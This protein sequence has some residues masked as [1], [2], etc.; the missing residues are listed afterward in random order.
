MV[1]GS[2]ILSCNVEVKKEFENTED[3]LWKECTWTRMSDNAICQ[4][5][6]IDDDT[7]EKHRCEDSIANANMDDGYVA[8]RFECSI[9]INPLQEADRE[10]KGWK[11]KLQKCMDKKDGGCISEATSDCS[12]EII[13]NTTVSVVFIYKYSW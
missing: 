10:V 6:A 5:K 9:T 13:V 4:Q 12:S 11:C 2:L 3:L 1:S 8:N 7:L